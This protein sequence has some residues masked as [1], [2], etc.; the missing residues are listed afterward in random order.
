MIG[1]DP[2]LSNKGPTIG[3]VIPEIANRATDPLI[4]VRLQPNSFSR[5]VTK[6][7]K[8]Y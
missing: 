2:Y 6:T 7:P 8:E 5:G 4:S 3:A 1:L